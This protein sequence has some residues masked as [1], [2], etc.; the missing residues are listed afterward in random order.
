MHS[1]TNDA[2]G[3]RIYIIQLSRWQFILTI[4]DMHIYAALKT[5]KDV[6]VVS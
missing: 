2:S 4:N 3:A 6:H 1:E 5:L